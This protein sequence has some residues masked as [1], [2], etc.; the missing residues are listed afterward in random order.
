MRRIPFNFDNVEFLWKPDDPAF[1]VMMNS[2]TFRAIGF[3][4]YLCMAMRDAEAVITDPAIVE[5]VRMFRARGIGSL[6]RT[7]FTPR[8]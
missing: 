4:K 1:S 8:R 2:V 3:E 6:M 5:E 7:R